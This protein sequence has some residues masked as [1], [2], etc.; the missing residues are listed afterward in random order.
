MDQMED[1]AQVK[2]TR[3]LE[4]GPVGPVRGVGAHFVSL[5]INSLAGWCG[6]G[7][8]CFDYTTVPGAQSP[9]ATSFE[10]R[11]RRTAFSGR[12]QELSRQ[13]QPAFVFSA[14]QFTRTRSIN[15]PHS[16]LLVSSPIS[17]IDIA[18]SIVAPFCFSLIYVHPSLPP[19]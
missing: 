1:Q 6:L 4:S 2:E 11:R 18:Y 5:R 10:V 17:D 19:A 7:L 8:P 9:V 15:T 14:G 13:R 3:A 16:P 12:R